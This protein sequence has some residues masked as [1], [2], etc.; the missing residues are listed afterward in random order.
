MTGDSPS[1]QPQSFQREMLLK[2]AFALLASAELGRQ[3]DWSGPSEVVALEARV[4]ALIVLLDI[5]PR[6]E[7]AR[8]DTVLSVWHSQFADGE[9][10]AAAELR[11]SAR[12]ALGIGKR[13]GHSAGETQEQFT[14]AAALV[15]LRKGESFPIRPQSAEWTDAEARNQC[16][17][18]L[19]VWLERV[20]KD[21]R[22]TRLPAVI[23]GDAPVELERVYV[24]LYAVQ[25]NDLR[26]DAVADLTRLQRMS[27]RSLASEHPAIN[28]AAMVSRALE[29]CIVVGEPGSGK[30]T[31]IQWLV[32]A[33]HREKLPDFDA[34]L[35]VELSM[36]ADAIEERP[37]L[38]LLEFFFESL[39]TKLND[40]RPAASWMRR[41]AAENRR[42][43][44]LLDGWDEVPGPLREQVRQRVAA[45]EPFFVTVITS[46][47][48]GLPRQL[49]S[50][51][52]VDLYHIARLSERAT[53]EFVEKRLQAHGKSHLRDSILSRI[54]EEDDFGQM[55]GNPFLLGLLVGV[56][57][58]SAGRG[59]GP[60]TRAEMYQQ[61]TAWVKEQY[62]QSARETDRLTAGHLAGLRR[63]AYELLF[64]DDRP[65][66]TFREGEL[67]DRLKDLH[68][69]PISRSRFIN[70]VDYLCD[71]YSFLHAT[72]EE[73][74]AAEHAATL[75]SEEAESF[76]DR[77]FSSSSR[78]IVL[79]FAAGIG[80][81]LSKSCGKRSA[82]WLR[83]RDRYLQA[84]LRVARLI[85]A[86][87]W[88]DEFPDGIGRSV[89]DELWQEVVS[90]DDMEL[91]KLAV[92]GFA[93]M[94]A[95]DLCRRARKQKD[96]ST[97]AI[98]CMTNAVPSSVARREG[99]DELLTGEWET[100]AGTDVRGGAT[101][102]EI[103]SIRQALSDPSLSDQDRREAAIRAGAAKDQGAVA[104]LLGIL[105][106]P[107]AE[108]NLLEQTIFSLGLIGG[109]DATDALIR[110]VLGDPPFDDEFVLMA[111]AAL[112]NVAGGRKALDPPG[113]D[114]LLRRVAALPPETP[115]LKFIFAALE[116]FP[117]RDGA[118]VIAHIALHKNLAP[119]LRAEAVR[120]LAT[121]SERPL[122]QEMLSSIADE[123]SDHVAIAMLTVAI[124][125]SQSVPLEW[126][127]DKI[128]SCRER[129]KL[130]QLIKAYVLLVPY[131]PP[132]EGRRATK[133][134]HRMI[135]A[136]M[137]KTATAMDERAK[138]LVQA[139]ATAE[140]AERPYLSDQTLDLARV[141][142][143]RFAEGPQQVAEGCV[144][145]AASVL[146]HF[147]NPASRLELKKGL[148]TALQMNRTRDQ[149]GQGSER[150]ATALARSLAA[151]APEELLAYPSDCTSVDSVL[152]SQ[153]V[154]EGWMV[155]SDRI[156]DAEGV[157]I[158]NRHAIDDR[159]P[160]A[161]PLELADLVKR[162]P[163]ARRRD[164]EAYCLLIQ[165][166]CEPA[167]SLRTIHAALTA[168]LKKKAED[169]PYEFL[170]RLYPK[171][172]PKFDAWKKSLGRTV[173]ELSAHPGAD[174]SLR[175]VGL[176][177]R[178]DSQS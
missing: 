58:R 125:R 21:E 65:R 61:V 166:P 42:F 13:N 134:L 38:S 74:F 171:A 169:G 165:G 15:H 34:A 36:F 95:E 90:S 55:A 17:L 140:K 2:H 70:Q 163:P 60:R 54:E 18:G 97:W 172:A 146:T 83:Q 4:D 33:T 3:T 141:A 7:L 16:G 102:S 6:T 19:G 8:L 170:A 44:L 50:G 174:H 142:V 127:E 107:R 66:Y 147:R 81:K 106:S 35:F 45:E 162:L 24:E 123:P 112:R 9:Q 139:L 1:S 161:A 110:M 84:T 151:V 136:S 117:V 85:A 167:D 138:A 47:P 48:S 39:G 51:S 119:D 11:T 145:L 149:S 43:L 75:S 76:M 56:L 64:D 94:D 62:N 46:R 159:A 31:L 99:L 28:A 30:S 154:R 116:G 93:A 177:A 5:I 131:A 103:A 104:A 143:T 92:S 69:E 129:V 63:L 59:R 72:F 111:A 12:W 96:L 175:L 155:F 108:R 53:E 153:A 71:E 25:V 156:T 132:T 27:A 89:R 137:K 148:D 77:A 105:N 86:G 26:D 113:R 91:T 109:R 130:H 79:E 29:R 144:L 135:A 67:A 68:P 80:G 160:V 124:E 152:R 158:A 118:N 23:P 126:L 78:F 32:W 115:H 10:V 40:W 41:A 52:R 82:Q 37:D 121:A 14:R 57:A 150:L 128:E 164:F 22:W 100:F 173:K 20:R 157:E 168:C 101:E 178:R 176:A 73:F 49:L 114:R 87:R 120:V 88:S 133:F 122:V 98:E